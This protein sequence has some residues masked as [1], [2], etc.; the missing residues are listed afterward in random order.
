M[1]VYIYIYFKLI[2]GV[3]FQNEETAF[4]EVVDDEEEQLQE[5]LEYTNIPRRLKLKNPVNT[6]GML[7]KIKSA[8]YISINYYWKNLTKSDALLASLLDSRMKDLSFVL[9]DKCNDTKDLLREKY[10]E[11]QSSTLQPIQSMKS[12]V[13]KK[14]LTILAGLKKAPIRSCDEIAEYLQLEEIDLENNP[15]IWW[16]DREEKFPILSL[17]AKK[18]LSVYACSTAS[19]RLFSDAGNLLTVK[20]TRISPNLFKNLIFLKR[21]AKHLNSIHKPDDSDQFL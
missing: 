15:F 11:I 9:P 17:L 7:N 10:N 1:T 20:R 12:P 14:K 19:E 2:L 18:Y 5:L 13:K 8:L 3:S 6:R 16:H 4:D 21:N